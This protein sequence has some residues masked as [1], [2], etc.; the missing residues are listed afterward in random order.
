MTGGGAVV[1]LPDDDAVASAVAAEL[2]EVLAAAQAEG[3]IPAV[4][5][6]GGT[7]ARKVHAA[8][9]GSADRDRVDWASVEVWWGDERFVPAG[10]QE[11]NE[12]QAR[13]DLLSAVPVDDERVHAVAASDG[14]VTSVEAAAAYGRELDAAYAGAD[15]PWFDVLMLGIGPDGHCASLFPGRPE[16]DAGGTTVAVT[17]SPKPPPERVSLTLPTLQRARQVW[18]V[19]SGES[20]ADA[21]ARSYASDD[22]HET[23]SAGPRGTEDTRWYVDEAAAS[24]L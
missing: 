5:L 13:A 3:R 23:P 21:V 7:I 17:D 18:F 20:K 22:V 4:V 16:V 14:A 2:I 10:D 15:G 1:R 9:A 19:A 6:T 24:R 12:A 11:R 8:V